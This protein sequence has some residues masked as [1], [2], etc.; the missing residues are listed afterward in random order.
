MA[1]YSDGT[2]KMKIL[3]VFDLNLG[4]RMAHDIFLMK[5][6]HALADSGHN[7]FFLVGSGDNIPSVWEY[8]GLPYNDNLNIIK[9]P[10]IHKRKKFL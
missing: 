7:V 1:I 5:M 3:T 10:R 8:Y 4:A 9:I 6:C 2:R